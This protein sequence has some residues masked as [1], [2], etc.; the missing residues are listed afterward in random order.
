MSPSGGRVRRNVEVILESG[1]ARWG[2]LPGPCSLIRGLELE[3][4][5]R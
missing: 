5:H 2:Y 3:K 1:G 4:L